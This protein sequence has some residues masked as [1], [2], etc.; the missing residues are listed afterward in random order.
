MTRSK[1]DHSDE[2]KVLRWKIDGFRKYRDR[3]KQIPE[4]LALQKGKGLKTRQFRNSENNRNENNVKDRLPEYVYYS[5]TN[6]L[7]KRLELLWLKET[8]VMIVSK[9]VMKSLVN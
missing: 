2:Y 5:T 8:L 6:D 4:V 3:I 9:C 1:K 7:F